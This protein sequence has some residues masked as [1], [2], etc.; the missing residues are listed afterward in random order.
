M[1]QAGY[2]QAGVHLARS[3]VL[4]RYLGYRDYL[5]CGNR[6]NRYNCTVSLL[7]CHH[8]V[9]LCVHHGNYKKRTKDQS[10]IVTDVTKPAI[11]SDYSYCVLYL[12]DLLYISDVP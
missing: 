9:L 7:T 4:C 3:V 5:P 8:Y 11:T 1:A 2:P 6:Q 12:Y 10:K